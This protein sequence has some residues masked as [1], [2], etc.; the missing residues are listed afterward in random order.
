MTLV[1]NGIISGTPTTAGTYNFAVQVQDSDTP[2][3]GTTQPLSI[4]VVA[5]L[6]I[7]TSSLPDGMMNFV[8]SQQLE[9]VGGIGAVAWTV[10]SGSLPPGLSLD[11]SSGLLSG[12]PTVAGSYS[13]TIR[14][15]DSASPPRTD[16]KEFTISVTAG[17]GMEMVSLATN[18]DQGNS[19]S[20]SPAVSANGRFIAFI[21]KPGN[22]STS[23]A[24]GVYLRDLCLGADASCSVS[25]T[26]VSLDSGNNPAGINIGET[27][28]ISGDGRYV[29]FVV[30]VPSTNTG[31]V[32]EIFL[33]DTCKSQGLD[34]PGC[35]P[36]TTLISRNPNGSSPDG[37]SRDARI[38]ED[39]RYVAFDSVASGLVTGLTN[40]TFAVYVVDTCNGA[41]AGCVAGTSLVSRASDG[42][43]ANDRS[44][45]P[46]IS[47]DGRYIAFV[48]VANNLVLND[49]NA[50]T[51]VFLRDTCVGVVFCTPSTIRVSVASDGSEGDNS[52]LFAGLAISGNGRFVSFVSLATN[53]VPG[54]NLPVPGQVYV[55]D[56]C[57]NVVPACAGSTAIVSV[58]PDGKTPGNGFSSRP[59]MSSDGRFV[60]FS[61]DASDLV[62]NDNNGFRDVFLRDMCVAAPAGCSPA[63]ARLSVSDSGQQGNGIS[64][65]PALS[66][67]GRF[68]AFTSAA[69][70]LVQHDLNGVDDV[71]LAGT[72]FVPPAGRPQK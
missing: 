70:N 14:A 38:S 61:S 8:Y 13:F 28:S 22:F 12:T 29:T 63:T 20:F 36:G 32:D 49:H 35:A 60:S 62:A 15:Q 18:G 66:P 19:D 44:E 7:A 64:D 37:S 53:L 43:V 34:V 56:T 33:R 5:T 24:A 65:Q 59:S 72:G 46:A 51:D 67:D 48:S 58:L 26:L 69:S 6:T 52:A 25:T 47:A 55:R 30:T 31:S 68:V 10:A 9:Q 50:A 4:Q 40:A 1:G 16:S 54:I 27:P 21:S 57:L 41:P 23:G 42:T 45:I 17:G 39:G 71:F 2:P 3:L 11:S